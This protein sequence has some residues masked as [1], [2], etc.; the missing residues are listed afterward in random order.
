FH[1]LARCL[2]MPV[3]P[4]QKTRTQQGR[5]ARAR[6]APN[7]AFL[8]FAHALH[9]S[10]ATPRRPPAAR[11]K[12]VRGR[13]PDLQLDV[14]PAHHAVKPDPPLLRD[15]ACRPTPWHRTGRRRLGV[16]LARRGSPLAHHKQ[17]RLRNSDAGISAS[18]Y[19][20]YTGATRTQQGRPARTRKAQTRLSRHRLVQRR[21]C[22]SVAPPY[23]GATHRPRTPPHLRRGKLA[24]GHDQ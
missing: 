3:I 10:S 7:S 21:H 23:R 20:R 4:A 6:N 19:A 1:H 16:K 15:R 2:C 8:V 24:T 22:P 18:P 12:L 13:S 11:A 17:G 14:H 9:I 5:P